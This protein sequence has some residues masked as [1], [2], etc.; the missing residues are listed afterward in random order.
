MT[1]KRG[2]SNTNKRGSAAQRRARKRWL[3]E[4]YR[5][6]VDVLI[7][8]FDNGERI[9]YPATPDNLAQ[10]DTPGVANVERVPATRCYRCG[11]LLTFETL[12]I[13]RRKPDCEGGTYWDKANLRPACGTCNSST[14]GALGAARRRA[15]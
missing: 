5:A 2:T 14:G 7:F 9:E 15:S 13:D 12:T 4:E 6:N 3:I 10:E 8:T 1:T 11:H